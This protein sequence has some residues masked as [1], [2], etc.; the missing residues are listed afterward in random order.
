MGLSEVLDRVTA[1][2]GRFVWFPHEDQ[3]H[4]VSLWIAQTYLVE[5][6]DAVGMLHVSSPTREC[7]KSLLLDIIELLAWEPRASVNMSN[8]VLFRLASEGYTLIFDEAD[9]IFGRAG[10]EEQRALINAAHRR[11]RKAMRM[12]GPP[13]GL[14]VEEF[15]VFAPIA[16]AGIGSLPDTVAS[17]CIPIRLQRKPK[18]QPR[19]RFRLRVEKASGEAEQLRHDFEAALAPV[20]DEIAA[21]FPD[22]PD[23]LTDRQMD[24]WES[25]LAI[26]DLAG[27]GW[28]RWWRQAAVKLHAG[29]DE[30]DANVAVQLLADIKAVFGDDDR[31]TTAALLEL[32]HGLEESP[33][34]DWFGKPITARF[35]ADKLRPFEIRS[36]SIRVGDS[37]PKGYERAAFLDAWDQYLTATSAT[38]ATTHTP[39]E[40]LPDLG[41]AT[42]RN[43]AA[44]TANVADPLRKVADSESGG[45]ASTARDVAN[46]ADVAADTA[47]KEAE[48][49]ADEPGVGV[50]ESP[51][52]GQVHSEES[53]ALTDP[54]EF[55]V[56]LD[57]EAQS[58]IPPPRPAEAE[59][60]KAEADDA[61]GVTHERS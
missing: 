20:A 45:I 60:D 37:T 12:T 14:R 9:N 52:T 40:D 59:P 26:C 44:T 22:M 53:D 8:A 1:Y 39:Q 4:A 2:I 61:A 57:E 32:L 28:E 15:D 42:T 21:A 48:A 38:D 41:S 19:A 54:F 11:G 29:L 7:G 36:K 50:G 30:P 25:L 35:L 16:L 33:W 18:T 49:A 5:C 6:L 3:L 51:E 56:W 23:E 47:G 31:L 13:G 43:V 27:G 55:E 46:V 34:S 10:D 24:C 17:R 58:D